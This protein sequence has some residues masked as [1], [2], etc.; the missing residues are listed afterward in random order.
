MARNYRID[1]DQ[2]SENKVYTLPERVNAIVFTNR[3][4]NTVYINGEP[5]NTDQSLSNSGQ[6]GE[7]DLSQYRI[8]FVG[9]GTNALY[10]RLKIYQ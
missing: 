3:G 5:L 6:E 9:A 2:V 4:T 8:N 1:S 10:I 7:L